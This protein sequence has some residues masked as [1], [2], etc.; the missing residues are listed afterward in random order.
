MLALDL[1]GRIAIVTGGS[2]GIG[3]A[4]ARALAASGA[5]VA[6]IGRDARAL[7]AA[8]GDIG[9]DKA[10]ALVHDLSLPGSETAAVQETQARFGR[11]DLL[12]NAAGASGGGDFLALPDAV[13][14]QSFD[15]KIMAT[16]RMIRAVLPLMLAQGWGRVVSIAGNSALHN[17][18]AM[19]PGAMANTTL[20]ALT[21]GLSDRHAG[22]G[23]LL[24]C[25]S[26][27]PTLTQRLSD[28]I[29]GVAAGEGISR[30]AAE[31]RLL[32][33][34]PTR[35]F[36]TPQDIARVVLFLCSPLTRNIS[37]INLTVDGGATR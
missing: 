11:V 37:G 34:T 1:D 29:D 10:L 9:A 16:I 35:R 7:D 20:I 22:E 5:C 26:P 27:G 19:L 13:W 33:Q 12:V 31:A 28:V 18:A 17:N 14:Q 3:L 30:A 15:L 36:C 4:A 6:L 24:N 23:V 32:A 25:I 2:K 8:V 21:K